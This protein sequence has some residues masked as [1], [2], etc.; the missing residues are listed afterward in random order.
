MKLNTC[1]CKLENM[2]ELL[3]GI[4]NGTR[5]NVLGVLRYNMRCIDN[6]GKTNANTIHYITMTLFYY[7]FWFFFFFF[8]QYCYVVPTFGYRN[9]WKLW[10]EITRSSIKRKTMSERR[11]NATLLQWRAQRVWKKKEKVNG[12]VEKSITKVNTYI[13]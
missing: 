2:L 13:I 6:S 12:C 7:Y 4:V 3:F 10:N 11:A 9:F 1:R 5:I 8:L